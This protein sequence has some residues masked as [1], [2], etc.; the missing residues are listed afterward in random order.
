MSD[1]T[2]IVDLLKDI[3]DKREDTQYFMDEAAM[4][5]N[6]NMDQMKA[7]GLIELNGTRS[8]RLTEKGYEV[9]KAGS[10]EKWLANSEQRQNEAHQAALDSAAATV[11]A[12]ASAKKSLRVAW[13]VGALSAIPIVLSVLQYADSRAKDKEISALTTELERVSRS[14]D[15]IQSSLAQ[16]RSLPGFQPIQP[17]TK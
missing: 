17:K 2:E 13:I 10:F 4:A 3:R 6:Q 8:N 12:T 1:S 14:I 7:Y 15:S 11:D 5:Y 16:S 9:I